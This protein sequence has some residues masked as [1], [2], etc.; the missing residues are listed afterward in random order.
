MNLLRHYDVGNKYFDYESRYEKQQDFNAKINGWY[1]FLNGMLTGL[2]VSDGKLYF[3][4]DT[5]KHVITE[6]SKA[7]VETGISSKMK[8][9]SLLNGKNKIITFSYELPKERFN[10]APLNIL[11]KKTLNGVIFKKNYKI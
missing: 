7:V 3:L 6:K 4:Y 5:N 8:N 1:K 10:A 2:L 11:M 9:F